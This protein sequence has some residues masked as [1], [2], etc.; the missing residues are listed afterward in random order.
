LNN[1]GR[2]ELVT[3]GSQRAV[4]YDPAT[5]KELWSTKGVE[6]NA[7]A[8]PV[9]GHGLVVVSSGYPDKRVIAIRLGGSGDLT[10]TDRIVWKY[11]KGTAVVPSPILSG[12]TRTTVRDGCV[13]RDQRRTPPRPVRFTATTST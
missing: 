5:G 10:G 2:A 12:K 6:G 3:S 7:I 1:G 8:T 11:E 4:A 9:A 13:F